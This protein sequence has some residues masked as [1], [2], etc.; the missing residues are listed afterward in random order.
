ML[1][2]NEQGTSYTNNPAI[3]TSELRN[4]DTNSGFY[5]VMHTDSPSSTLETFK[6]QINTTALGARKFPLYRVG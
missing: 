6:L 2:H 1:M 3:T 5:V 4:P